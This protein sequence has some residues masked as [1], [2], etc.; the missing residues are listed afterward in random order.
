ML[1]AVAISERAISDQGVLLEGAQSIFSQFELGNNSNIIAKGSAEMI[2]IGVKA[3]IGVGILTGIMEA[4][5]NFTQNA[6]LLRFA[7]GVSGMVCT[8]VQ[9]SSGTYVASALSEQDASFIQDSA[10]TK[11][12]ITSSEQSANFTQS[13]SANVDFSGAAA[14]DFE[15]SQESSGSRVNTGVLALVSEFELDETAGILI[16]DNELH[17]DFFF[18]QTTNGALLWEKIDAGA[19]PENWSPVAPSGGTWTEVDAN[20]NIEIWKKM[21]V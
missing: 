1:G 11:I 6:S 16:Y 7:T 13:S 12:A 4:S 21:V 10:A 8:S 5:A 14:V 18:V 15:F 9:T 3:S 2:A 19:S 20:G 17:V